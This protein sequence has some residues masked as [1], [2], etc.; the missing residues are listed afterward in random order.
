[1]MFSS[2]NTLIT[3]VTGLIFFRGLVYGS[4]VFEDRFHVFLF[5]CPRATMDSDGGGH[6]HDGI[7]FQ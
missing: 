3:L 5:C 2:T 1:M 6:H 7:Q 4:V